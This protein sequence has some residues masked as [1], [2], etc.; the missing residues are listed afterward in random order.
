MSNIFGIEILPLY[1]GMV[2]VAVVG[3]IGALVYSM[4]RRNVAQPSST[5]TTPAELESTAAAVS[6]V[7][8]SRQPLNAELSSTRLNPIYRQKIMDARAKATEGETETQTPA[9]ADQPW[10]TVGLSDIGL[11][12]NLNEDA[13]GQSPLITQQDKP[14]QLLI[15]ADGMGGHQGGDVASQVTVETVQQYF[16][17]QPPTDVTTFEE[18]LKAAAQAANQAVMARQENQARMDKMGSTLV[19]ALV[20]DNVAHIANVGDSRVYWLTSEGITQVTKDHSLVAR[21]VEMGQITEEEARHHPQ[22]NVIYST[23][24]DADKMYIDV[25]QQPLESGQRLLLCSDGLSRMVTDEAILE[26]SQT[27][28]DDPQAVCKALINAANEGGGVD[29][30]TVVLLDL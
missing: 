29:N 9:N 26:I 7:E 6:P 4:R 12:R 19:M 3:L 13:W 11:E 8:E 2:V 22:Q 24:G 5:S 21:L 1:V 16:T 25:Y 20:Y 17:D 10:Q 15:V 30:V 28:S 23:I 18:W 14:C 27:H